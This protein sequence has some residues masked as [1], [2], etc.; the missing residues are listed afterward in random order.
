MPGHTFLL[1]KEEVRPP[2]QILQVQLKLDEAG[3]TGPLQSN[4][5]TLLKRPHLDLLMTVVFSRIS[6]KRLPFG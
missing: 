4:I 2:D 3:V 1:A 6:A 5:D